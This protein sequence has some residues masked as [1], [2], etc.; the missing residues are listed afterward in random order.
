MVMD[1][2]SKIRLALDGIGAVPFVREAFALVA[3][4]LIGYGLRSLISARRRARAR[5]SRH[6]FLQ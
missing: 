5:Q 3:G 4:V 6:D 1:Y 2:Y